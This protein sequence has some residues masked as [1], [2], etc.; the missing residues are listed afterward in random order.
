MQ[1]VALGQL[2]A[3]SGLLAWL[4]YRDREVERDA[5]ARTRRPGFGAVMRD[6]GLLLLGGV[7]WIYAGVQLSLVGFLV[8]F[9]RALVTGEFAGAAFFVGFA[10]LFIWQVGGFI[11]RNRPVVYAFDRIPEE[12]LP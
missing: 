7:T 3:G 11:R 12:L 5:Q 6:P 4:L 1:V 2:T 10:A 9:L 8:L